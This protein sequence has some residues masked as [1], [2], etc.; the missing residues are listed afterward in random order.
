MKR[1][2]AALLF[3]LSAGLALAQQQL[4]VIRLQ[5]RTAEQVLPQLKP[6]VEQGGVL[7][8]T[9]DRIFLRASPGNRR[10]IKEI[11]AALD[12]PPRRLLITL[13]HDTETGA[14]T[15]DA[16]A[17]RSRVYESR[18]TGADRTSQQVQV[19]EGGK[20]FIEVGIS[21]P[22]P[23]RRVVLTPGGVIVSESVVYRDLGTGF[24]AE[25]QLA[26]DTVT[27]EISPTHDTPADL[28]P[29][30]A[31]LQRLSTRVSVRLGEWV[32]IGGVNQEQ[33][34][35]KPGTQ[36]YSTRGSGGRRR[37]LLKVEEQ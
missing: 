37:V 31:N 33:G 7:S 13:L 23:L 19:A 36:T 29:G 5:H 2:F 17:A 22:I 14:G 9:N 32:E 3:A 21:L 20:A 18:S 34:A 30:S 12:R 1:I 26:G 27:L 4:E 6:F 25:P 15:R 28:G 24:Y 10:Q 11:L 8:G 35:D 16:D